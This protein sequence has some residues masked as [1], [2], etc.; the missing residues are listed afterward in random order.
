MARVVLC[1]LLAASAHADSSVPAA[2]PAPFGPR[3]SA[4]IER[5]AK[6]YAGNWSFRDGPPRPKIEGGRL[7]LSYHVSDMCGV[8]AD[9]EITLARDRRSATA[10]IGHESRNSHSDAV[11]TRK[12]RRSGTLRAAIEMEEAGISCGE[13]EKTFEPALDVCL[14]ESK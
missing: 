10:W 12:Y 2:S 1:L 4:A 3:C 11:R 9:C 7:T 8:Q 14:G 5:A 13:F 6:A